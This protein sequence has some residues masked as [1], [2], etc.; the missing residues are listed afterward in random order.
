[1]KKT[2][3]IDTSIKKLSPLN[4]KKSSHK[5]RW[6]NLKKSTIELFREKIKD[7]RSRAGEIPQILHISMLKKLNNKI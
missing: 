4:N 5:P 3:I 2:H 1:L 7:R 6:L